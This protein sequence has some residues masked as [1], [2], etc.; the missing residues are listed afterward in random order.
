VFFGVKPEFS[1][2]SA[3]QRLHVCFSTPATRAV[4]SRSATPAVQLPVAVS[5]PP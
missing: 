4:T 3:S 1:R 5:V 2:R